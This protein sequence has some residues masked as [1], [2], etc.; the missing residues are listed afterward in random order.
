M[1]ELAKRR[2]APALFASG[3]ALSLTLALLTA[4]G[5]DGVDINAA[6]ASAPILVELFTSQSC[7]SCPPAEAYARTLAQQSDLVVIE[8][9]VD[10]WDDLVYGAAGAWK[11]PFS[12]ARNTRRQRDYARAINGADRIYTPQAVVSGA[13]EVVGSNRRDVQEAIA[14]APPPRALLSLDSL[15]TTMLATVE[16]IGDDV[17]TEAEVLF[18]RLK[19]SETTDVARG[20]NHGKTLVNSNIALG[21]RNL[22]PWNGRT[23]VFETPKIAPGETCALIIQE[24]AQGRPVGRVLGAAYCG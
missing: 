19:A 3:A 14:N 5:D 10:Y 9:H 22:G 12:H 20:E 23:S 6:A 18:V 1:S 13:S 15:E 11:D 17:A 7:S 16:P 24:T 8:W 2:L 21:V 4:D